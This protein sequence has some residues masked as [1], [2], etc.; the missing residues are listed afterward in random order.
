[1][2]KTGGKNV[3]F[4]DLDGILTGFYCFE[5]KLLTVLTFFDGVL[6]YF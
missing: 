6:G 5:S 4:D 2:E 3:F 1:M